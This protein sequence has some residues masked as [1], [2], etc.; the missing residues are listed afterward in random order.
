[1]LYRTRRC[2]APAA[3]TP[4][5][6]VFELHSAFLES[7][8]H[9]SPYA[10]FAPLHYE[11][12]YG[13]PLLV[14]LHGSQ[15]DERQLTRI[16]P[17][18]SMRNYVAIAP[19]GTALADPARAAAGYTWDTSDEGFAQAQQRVFDCIHT[20]RQKLHIASRRVFL[21]GFDAGGTMAY[22]VALAH[23][24]RFAGV[25]SLSG[26]FP[27]GQAA[28]RNLPQARRL[29]VFLA[30]GRRSTVYGPPSAST[31][32]RLLHAAGMSVVL[33]EYPCGQ[34]LA[35]QMMR[36]LDRWIIEQITSPA[37]DEARV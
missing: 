34:E 15:C 33:R 13:Y 32:L 23:A 28:L 31:D 7:R 18:V 2:E 12:R 20:A 8:C 16:M 24:E 11:P 1:M 5:E 4:A 29:P 25:I 35:P 36:D 19:R 22:R 37:P 10:L 9:D 14:W 3:S 6:P 21:A 27:A 30:L 26:P 17:L